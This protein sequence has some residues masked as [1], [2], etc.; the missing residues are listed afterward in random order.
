MRALACMRVCAFLPSDESPGNTSK[1]ASL[2]G[3]EGTA[4]T[5]LISQT[6]SAFLL[7]CNALLSTVFVIKSAIIKFMPQLRHVLA[8]PSPSITCNW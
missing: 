4:G 3:P 7:W 5:P 1:L 2:E 8:P 6:V